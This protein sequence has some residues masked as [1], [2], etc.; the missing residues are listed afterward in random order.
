[1]KL[2]LGDFLV[3]ALLLGG[4][5]WWGYNSWSDHAAKARA[6]VARQ[7]ESAEYE[8]AVG[9]MATRYS[10]IPA[11]TDKL[12]Q[13]GHVYTYNVQNALLAS[14]G[15]AVTFGATVKD[16]KKSEG[17]YVIELEAAGN[18]TPVLHY[19]LECDAVNAQKIY[20]ANPAVTRVMVV[21]QI[22]AVDRVEM[23][24]AAT[25]EAVRY[26]ARGRCLELVAR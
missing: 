22:A 17:G 15:R 23:P 12:A 24:G 18:G 4:L 13:A 2:S 25:A 3:P 9:E 26:V 8:K 20:A 1:M 14:T 16:L 21:A 7:H 6:E 5:G 19:V 11:L 10:A